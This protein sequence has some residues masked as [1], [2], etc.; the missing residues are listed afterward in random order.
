MTS[1]S[2]SQAIAVVSN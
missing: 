2:V 1:P